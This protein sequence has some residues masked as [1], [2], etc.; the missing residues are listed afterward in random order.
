LTTNHIQPEIFYKDHS[1]TII[2]DDVLSRLTT[3]HNVIVCG[4]QAFF[5]EEA[6]TEIADVTMRNLN[7]FIEGKPCPNT[8]LKDQPP[9]SGTFPVRTI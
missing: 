6:L 9:A 4:H 3:F 7:D 5:T 8:L 1:G 2:D